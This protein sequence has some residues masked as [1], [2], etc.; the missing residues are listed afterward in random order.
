MTKEEWAEAMSPLTRDQRGA[1]L[2]TGLS[3]ALSDLAKTN[4]TVRVDMHAVKVH[5]VRAMGATEDDLRSLVDVVAIHS[6][7]VALR[8]LHV[9]A[10]RMSDLL[11]EARRTFM[12]CCDREENRQMRELQRSQ[13]AH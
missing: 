12:A 7:V 8:C 5:A 6:P 9:A 4:P 10:E 1:V 11:W 13:V 3:V 2:C